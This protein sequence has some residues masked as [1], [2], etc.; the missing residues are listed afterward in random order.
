MVGQHHSSR[1]DPDGFGPTGHIANDNS[2]C[3]TGNTSH[4]VMLGKPVAMVAPLLRV[5]RQI[6]GMTQGI[7]SS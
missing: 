3:R 7:G 6:K 1:S 2:S 4:I 5:L